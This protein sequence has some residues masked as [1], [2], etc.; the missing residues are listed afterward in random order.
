[1]SEWIFLISH[2]SSICFCANS[3]KPLNVDGKSIRTA[4]AKVMLSYGNEDQEKNEE[5]KKGNA[6]INLNSEPD[7][8]P[9]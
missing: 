5:G 3:G 9:N 4:F 8:T 2:P 6:Q 7:L 1:M